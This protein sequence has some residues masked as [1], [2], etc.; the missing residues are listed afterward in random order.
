PDDYSLNS[1]EA[2]V[3]EVEVFAASNLLDEI[4]EIKTKDI[5]LSDIKESGT[6][7]AELDLPDGVVAPGNNTVD[8]NIE[9]E[10]LKEAGKVEETRSEE[11]RVGKKSR[12]RRR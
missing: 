12:R 10:Q 2:A 5:D 9:I 7:E 4:N 1:I 3:D 11:R 8:V 6:V